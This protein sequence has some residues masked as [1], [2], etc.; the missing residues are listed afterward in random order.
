MIKK[1]DLTPKMDKE[2]GCLDWNKD[3]HSL[4]NLIRGINPY[5]GAFTFLNGRL[6]KI[7]FAVPVE[8][9]TENAGA[10]MICDLDD[11]LGL[12]VQT[13]K[14]RLAVQEVQPESKKRMSAQSF[15]S[16]YRS[17]PIGEIF[18]RFQNECP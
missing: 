11:N 7:W 18:R 15:I 3:N 8:G 16:G 12:I 9:D 13:G 1:T 17:T 6:I 10:G 4:C 5:P 14:G 2:I